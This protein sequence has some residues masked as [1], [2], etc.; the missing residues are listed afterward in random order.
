MS[1]RVFEDENEKI[2][3]IFRAGARLEVQG[4][5][6]SGERLYQIARSCARKLGIKETKSGLPIESISEHRRIWNTIWDLGMKV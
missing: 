2:W 3:I 5:R 6:H 4:R 1:Y